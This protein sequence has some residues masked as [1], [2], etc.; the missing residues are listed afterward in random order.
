VW[1]LTICAA[2]FA[3]VLP[4]ISAVVIFAAREQ[5]AT[6][7]TVPIALLSAA[8]GAGI[9]GA[10][11]STWRG[12]NT[13]RLV[14]LVLVVMFYALL[15]WSNWTTATSPLPEVVQQRFKVTAMRSLLWIPLYLWYFLRP[16]TVAWY[17]Q[18]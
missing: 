6:P 7:G 16:T 10:A 3:G 8:L 15:A 13:S 5:L 12:S 14:L 4:I 2:V 18:P 9:I 11:V 17:R 1:I